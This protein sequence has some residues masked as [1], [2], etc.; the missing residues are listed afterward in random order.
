MGTSEGQD[1]LVKEEKEIFDRLM[2]AQELTGGE[3]LRLREMIA[4]VNKSFV[5]NPTLAQEMENVMLS[6]A[7]KLEVDE[8]GM[9]Y[10][11]DGQMTTL[12]NLVRK[13]K[14]KL[15]DAAEEA[16]MPVE[17]FE[18]AMLRHDRARE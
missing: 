8:I 12:F 13:G 6:R 4:N 3:K 17:A 15:H 11:E 9:P 7:M 2:A 18:D 5:K 16:N 1:T 14:L 10:F